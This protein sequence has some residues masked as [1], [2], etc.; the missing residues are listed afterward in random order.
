MRLG[1]T[2]NPQ[3][4]GSGTEIKEHDF[5]STYPVTDEEE[6]QYQ[7]DEG[8]RERAA[9][10]RRTR[11]ESL[12]SSITRKFS[13]KSSCELEGAELWVWHVS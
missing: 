12:T 13:I 10:G 7:L 3:Q 5:F 8:N 11:Q 6:V 2:N 9:S 4:T 1:Y